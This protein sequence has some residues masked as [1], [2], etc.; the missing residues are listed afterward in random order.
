MHSK[1][2][3]FSLKFFPS[4]SIVFPIRWER[5]VVESRLV[6]LVPSYCRLL[7]QGRVLG[8]FYYPLVVG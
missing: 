6:I 2:M 5:R 1:N 4:K 8:S 7:G 3:H